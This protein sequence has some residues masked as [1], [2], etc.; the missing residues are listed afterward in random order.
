M[1]KSYRTPAPAQ[2]RGLLMREQVKRLVL[3]AAIAAT[4]AFA[5]TPAEAFKKGG[6]EQLSQDMAHLLGAPDRD[7]TYADQWLIFLEDP[8][9]DAI[10]GFSL[11]F[12]YDP[13]KFTF[14]PSFSGVVCGFA[15]G[16]CLPP[17]AKYGTYLISDF[18]L[19]DFTA[20]A[21]LP[22]STLTVTNDATAGVVDVVYDLGSP[23][24]LPGDDTN[25]FAFVFKPVS[26]YNPYKSEIT[27]YDT[28][29]N[30]DFNCLR[31]AAFQLQRVVATHRSTAPTS[32]CHRF[33]SRKPGT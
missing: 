13:S 26:P 11:T 6:S 23:L 17:S 19:V 31:L 12:G 33:P 8:A 18:P 2:N 9:V 22:G 10:S 27:F 4:A 30:Y 16:T 7:L 15:V 21:P 14:E 5:S 20:G 25:I 28:P 32:S 24:T 29:G 3:A 1:L